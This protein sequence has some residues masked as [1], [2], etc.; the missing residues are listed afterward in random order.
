[1]DDSRALA[2]FQR[3]LLE[4][5]YDST[6]PNDALRRLQGDRAI[7][8]FREYVDSFELRA[9]G[10]GR[11]LVHQWIVEEPEPVDARVAATTMLAAVVEKPHAPVAIRRV[12]RGIVGPGQVRLQIA[13]S[14]ICGTDL[15]IVRDDYPL[16]L[17]VVLG[18]EP[19]GT[20][21]E[22]GAG[23][24]GLALGDRVGV[25]WVQRTCGACRACQAGRVAYCAAPR[26]WIQG[27]G[28][29]A[30]TMIAEA[31][32]C[33]KLP[34]GLAFELAAPL[35][36]AGHTVMSGY[37][38]A[39]PAPTDRVA[40]LGIGGLGHL[41]I[42]IAKALG[43]EVVAITRTENKRDEARALGADEVLVAEEDPGEALARAG[44]ADIALCT[45]NALAWSARV[46]AGMRA[47][48]RIALLAVGPETFSLSP[49]SL[50]ARQLEIAGA[51]PS[52]EKELT[53]VLDLAA[54]GLVTPRV[55][56]YPLLRINQALTRLDEGSVRYRAVLA[57][58]SI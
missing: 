7:R 2:A 26:T 32:G 9:V 36:C 8:P 18:H 30:E 53:D 37:R 51:R 42:Q 27:G 54:R 11:E 5:L 12:A 16:P 33:T 50:I 55:E 19:V 56:V 24:N 58:A 43:H 57:L 34:D 39:R 25:R 29:H 23:V 38:R 15:H 14:G 22:L 31:S 45:S 6:D 46:V 28:G 21:V 41:A 4:A 44:G 10:V 13:A 40:V 52:S 3:A 35:F 20:V 1:M 49:M 48:G 17:P 47:E